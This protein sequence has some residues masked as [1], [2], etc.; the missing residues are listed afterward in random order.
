MHNSN[1]TY[2]CIYLP[3]TKNLQS[4]TWSAIQILQICR[5]KYWTEWRLTADCTSWSQPHLHLLQKLEME[6]QLHSRLSGKRRN[7]ETCIRCIKNPNRRSSSG[8]KLSRYNWNK[9][10]IHSHQRKPMAAVSWKRRKG[11]LRLFQKLVQSTH[12]SSK[13]YQKKKIN[14]IKK[15]AILFEPKC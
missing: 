3:H 15:P 1:I 11:N 9:H 6:P 2:F 8:W 12:D 10:G 7:L 14:L 5:K 13:F 4:K